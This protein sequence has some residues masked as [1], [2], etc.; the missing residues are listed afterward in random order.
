MESRRHLTSSLAALFGS[1]TLAALPAVAALAGCGGSNGPGAFPNITP[2]AAFVGSGD[3]A[4]LLE[5][6]GSLLNDANLPACPPAPVTSFTPEWK[7]PVASK[8]G[9]CTSA[10]I[11][12]FFDACLGPASTPANCTTYTQA[13]GSCASCLQ[14]DDT[15]AQYGPVIWHASRLFYTTNIAGCIANVQ[16]D[17]GA[18]GCGAAYQA[19][20]ECKQ[21]ACAACMTPQTPDFSRYATCENKA[22]TECGSYITTL[23]NT[24]GTTLK[25]PSNPISVC[26]PPSGD[27]PQDA[28][29]RL[30]PIFCGK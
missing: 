15:A 28:Y 19:V 17:G 24:C 4:S 9:A 6:A 2:D 13:N 22:A 11:S 12:S 16:A 27:T 18:A 26:I 5:D 20:V 7:P 8:S 10:Q 1:L 30:A 3:A 25:D 14:A 29:L 23:T 21:T